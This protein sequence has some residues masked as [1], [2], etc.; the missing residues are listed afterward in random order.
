MTGTLVSGLRSVRNPQQGRRW[1]VSLG[2]SLEEV[3]H[4]DD[5]A[6]R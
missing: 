3:T 1:R 5:P 4:E 2:W 6:E